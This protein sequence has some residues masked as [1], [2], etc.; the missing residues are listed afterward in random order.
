VPRRFAELLAIAVRA[1]ED[2][3]PARLFVVVV[4]LLAVVHG[5]I[6]SHFLVDGTT[7][8]LVGFLVVLVLVPLLESAT[9]PGGGGLTFRN[10]LDRLQ[11]E[12]QATLDAPLQSAKEAPSVPPS[13]GGERQPPPVPRSPAD[14]PQELLPPSSLGSTVARTLEEASRS[15]RIGLMYLASELERA[16]R[17]LLASTGWDTPSTGRSL[18]DGINRLVELGVVPQSMPSALE[19][20]SLVRNEVVHG[21]Q[22]ATDEEVVRALDAGL[23][24]LHAIEAV[25]RERHFV[26]SVGVPVFGDEACTE[27]IESADGI[28]LRSVSPGGQAATLRIFPT[29]RKTYEVG[30]EVAWEWNPGRQWGP[31]WYRDD[32]FGVR[33]AWLGSME[34]VG[35]HLDDI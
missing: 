28:I 33:Q 7:L 27:R 5:V 16:T 2:V 15:P 35:R 21:R 32:D 30:R 1:L 8:A 19:L 9:L 10:N 12:A 24:L 31:A 20:F 17:N 18:R 22:R 34:F 11:Q 4:V 29:T 14:G 25:P 26:V 13:E 3:S 6:P 23:T